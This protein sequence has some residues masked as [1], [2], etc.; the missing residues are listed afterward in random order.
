[1]IIIFCLTEH[2][3]C[4]RGRCHPDQGPR[5]RR[6]GPP[7]TGSHKG[8]ATLLPESPWKAVPDIYEP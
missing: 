3:L 1:M 6:G 5:E 8:L 2:G 7:Q 4:P